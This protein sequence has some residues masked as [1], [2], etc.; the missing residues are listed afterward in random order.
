M[1]RST[2]KRTN[3]DEITSDSIPTRPKRL[4]D[5]EQ[6]SWFGT[7]P[8]DTEQKAVQEHL[9]LSGTGIIPDTSGCVPGGRDRRQDSEAVQEQL[10]LS[11]G[12][13][14]TGTSQTEAT[15]AVSNYITSCDRPT[16]INDIQSDT[17]TI[18]SETSYINKVIY[19][20]GTTEAHPSHFENIVGSTWLLLT[21]VT[22][23]PYISTRAGRSA[24]RSLKQCKVLVIEGMSGSGKSTLGLHLMS[25]MSKLTGRTPVKLSSWKQWDLIPRNSSN[26]DSN[27]NGGYIV[28]FDDIFGSNNLDPQQVEACE[29]YFDVMWP[30]ALTGHIM[31]IFISRSEISALCKHQLKKCELI[32]KAHVLN[33]DGIKHSLTAN[34]KRKMLKTICKIDEKDMDDI[35]DIDISLG[36]PQCCTYFANSKGAQKK[37][38]AFF[39]KPHEFIL[40]DVDILQECDGAGYLVL[41]LVLMTGGNLGNEQL[42][43]LKCQIKPLIANLR[44]CCNNISDSLTLCDIAKKSDSLC[45]MYLHC[46]DDGYQFQH[47]SVF[48]AVFVSISKRYPDICIDI[49]PTNMLV[50]LVRTSLTDTDTSDSMLCL[51]DQYFPA[52]A[53][54]IT[55]LLMSEDYVD[56]L[57]HPSFHHEEFVHQLLE[58]WTGDK[59]TSL[60][61]Q[62]HNS[63]TVTSPHPFMIEGTVQLFSYCTLFSAVV[64]KKIA[65]VFN[66]VK[67]RITNVPLDLPNC[68]AC[69]IYT[70]DTSAA[71]DLLRMGTVAD[72]SC[73]R[74]YCQSE[75]ME[76]NITDAIR[77]YVWN[78]LESIS[79]LGDLFGLAVMSGHSPAVDMLVAKLQENKSSKMFKKCLETL[80][81]DLGRTPPA[82]RSPALRHGKD[83]SRY[84]GVV[85]SLFSTGCHSDTSYL[86]WLSAGHPDDAIL[87]FFLAQ[88]DVNP[89]KTYRDYKYERKTTALQEAAAYGGEDNVQKLLKY[90]KEKDISPAEFLNRSQSHSDYF[91]GENAF[92]EAFKHENFNCLKHLIK[93]ESDV[94]QRDYLGSTLL[95]RA[96][97]AMHLETLETLLEKGACVSDKDKW[98]F[99]AFTHLYNEALGDLFFKEDLQQSYLESVQILTK[100]GSD[101]NEK[102]R[103]GETCLHK[104][105]RYGDVDTMRYLC[106]KSA[107]LNQTD[108][109]GRTPLH[110]AIDKCD[111]DTIRYL[112]SKGASVEAI[113]SGGRNVIH[114][115]ASSRMDPLEKIIYFKDTHNISVHVEDSLGRTVLFYAVESGDEEVVELFVDMG[116]DTNTQD[117]EGTSLLHIACGKTQTHSEVFSYK[118]I[119]S[120]IVNFLLEKGTDQ[121]LQD[122][123][124]CFP[125][126]YLAKQ[127]G[128]GQDLYLLIEKGADPNARDCNNCTPLHYAVLDDGVEENIEILLEK[129]A[130]LDARDKDGCTPLHVAA[131][132][133]DG[134]DTTRLL[135]EKG[136]D[137][138]ARNNQGCTPLHCAADESDCEDTVELFLDQGAD[139]CTQDKEGHIPLHYA[140]QKGCEESM[141]VLLQKDA[142]LST[143]DMHGRTPLHY[144]AKQYCGTGPMELLLDR[145]ADP[146]VRDAGGC[147][148]LH[149]AAEQYGYEAYVE[150]LIEREADVNLQDNDGLTPLH[151][152]ARHKRCKRTVEILLQNG[153]D[154]RVEDKEGSTPLQY[155]IKASDCSATVKLLQDFNS[156]T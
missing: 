81:M 136:A 124:E 85:Q 41:L 2:E 65:N 76:E 14:T 7:R 118:V 92:D 80:L 97:E 100:A 130:D 148:P 117:N 126:H 32:K 102:D 143:R 5:A 63:T 154:P 33:L 72:E 149:Y 120:Y 68:L 86:V 71:L 110:N 48:D 29:R 43:P 146:L 50:E 104:A 31:F 6:E 89:L 138:N 18:A 1:D 56:I 16:V 137:L 54:R 39:E 147:T 107:N 131:R 40:E 75:C 4:C 15:S 17:A 132:E 74:A 127:T 98:G 150:V 24:M 58:T 78:K 19:K 55:E 36:F 151:Y 23:K 140:T 88:P 128:R 77:S 121:F 52:F 3:R 101:V 21:N 35:V 9:G 30:H 45:G 82:E 90:F 155:A 79:D 113:D 125:L 103:N 27:L 91:E 51:S 112:V 46:S 70:D 59:M 96:A 49:C 129:G 37:G 94:R 83:A 42:D 116:L 13:T 135:L 152:A 47:Q 114:F 99:T 141:E 108:T 122:K 60:L 105:A 61:K 133:S 62:E 93:S 28:L 123:N 34:E 111:L 53:G 11:R 95:H 8:G 44:E 26:D 67:T 69:A 84:L 25:N 22:L 109:E 10:G 38:V 119:D 145:G 106:E 144:A 87:R 134:G 64:L 73:L 115:A 66:Y 153:A 57:C 156:Q 20:D 139:P 12:G 142:G